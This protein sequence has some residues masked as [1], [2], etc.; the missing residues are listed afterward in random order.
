MFHCLDP[1]FIKGTPYVKC[2]SLSIS[3]ADDWS[4]F[5]KASFLAKCD[6]RLNTVVDVLKK[7]SIIEFL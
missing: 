2:V 3:F 1:V 7:I 4:V 5:L 6:T